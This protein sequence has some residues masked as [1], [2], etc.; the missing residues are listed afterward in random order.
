[1]SVKTV[2]FYLL[3]KHQLQNEAALSMKYFAFRALSKVQR[4]SA[5]DSNDRSATNYADRFTHTDTHTKQFY[6]PYGPT[7]PNITVFLFILCSPRPVIYLYAQSFSL[8][9]FS[10]PKNALTAKV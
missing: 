7:R 2:C 6:L 8:E 3:L 9:H 1:M 4:N 5:D 10:F